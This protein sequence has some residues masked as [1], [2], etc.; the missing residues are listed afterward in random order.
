MQKN[1]KEIK[2]KSD[3][4]IETVGANEISRNLFVGISFSSEKDILW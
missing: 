2:S 4:E 3:Y 1:E